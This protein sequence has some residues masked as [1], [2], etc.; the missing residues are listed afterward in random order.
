MKKKTSHTTIMTTLEN[1]LCI[2]CGL[3][4]L[5]CPV[6][7]I[8]M[9]WTDKS[10]WEP[11]IDDSKCTKCGMCLNVCPN[12]SKNLNKSAKKAL[13]FKEEYGLSDSLGNKFAITWDNR[14]DVREKSPSGGTSTSLLEN[15]LKNNLVDCVVVAR[16]V[17]GKIGE[18][19]FET[20]VC[21]DSKDLFES[22]CSA[23]GPL[24]YDLVLAEVADRNETCA[25][26]VLPCLMRGISNLPEK[27]RKC[28]KYTIGI[29]C[30]HCVNDQFGDFLAVG[31]GIK[32]SDTFS[33][34]YRNNK[35]IPDANAYNTNFNIKD[36]KEIC[37]PR[38]TNGFTKVWR[39][40]FFA[41]E[42]CL[43]CPDF[44]VADADI[45]VKDAWGRLSVEPLGITL[46]IVRNSEIDDLLKN[47]SDD[48]KIYYEECDSS[49]IK[50][51]QNP[52]AAYKQIDFVT[53]WKHNKLLKK[54]DIVL[55]EKQNVLVKKDFL[56]KRRTLRL[57]SSLAAKLG[58]STFAKCHKVL[59]LLSSVLNSV[60]KSF[61][62]TWRFLYRCF[63]AIW[64]GFIRFIGLREPR[65]TSFCRYNVKEI[66]FLNKLTPNSFRRSSAFAVPDYGSTKTIDATKN[67]NIIKECI[68]ENNACSGDGSSSKDATKDVIINKECGLEN[69]DC[70]GDGSS[71]KTITNESSN[72]KSKLKILITGGYGYGNVGDEAQL[73]ANIRR[74]QD[75][76]DCSI[77]VFSPNPEYTSKHHG[78]E[79]CWAPRV[80]LFNSNMS[81]DYGSSNK[82]FEKTFRKKKRRLL[83]SAR[84]LRAGINLQF[85]SLEEAEMLNTIKQADVLHVSGGGF[86][87]GMTRSRLWETA[88]VMRLAYL[89]GT[90]VILT[91][92]TIGVFKSQQ[93]IK[94]TKWGLEKA[95]YISLRD[96]EESEKD[97]KSI[98]ISG[99]HVQS[100]FDDALFCDKIDDEISENILKEQLPES[101]KY[102]VANFHYWGQSI[103]MQKKASKRF[104]ELC[105][106]IVEKYDLQIMFVPM[107][108]SDEE[109]EQAVIRHM[110]SQNAV[111]LKYNYDY[112]VARGVISKAE[113]LLTMKHHPII[114]AHGEGVPVVSVTLDDYYYR[115][116]LGAM[117][118]CGQE[119][120]CLQSGEFFSEDAENIIDALYSKL[121]IERSNIHKY[122]DSVRGLNDQAQRLFLKE[123]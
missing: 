17:D 26:T 45:S 65:D 74:W 29:M 89:L 8:E 2:S 63:V 34:N 96:K 40:Y 103:T 69:N 85:T 53:R 82:A 106:H 20:F 115:K 121:I 48:N 104:A 52:T 38:L 93:D 47:L 18:P 31:N 27:Y 36:K 122:L 67:E 101:K 50:D 14:D 73:G 41:R 123:S 3:C 100:T 92:Q 94:L 114:F 110:K 70:S 25:I 99:K 116:N 112:K 51:S 97:L 84:F 13:E 117:Q 76:T 24:R 43:Y 9:V 86:L 54:S 30:S 19:H 71:P 68:L 109:A 87:T 119:K 77:K 81:G 5:V 10:C 49:E 90:P 83:L 39:E 7:C 102:V 91:G 79:S 32:A 113:F 95:Q 59:S 105:D 46:A 108:L 15:M 42:A 107:A 120:Y 6:D 37:T 72:T 56:K 78:V 66:A 98:G 80:V 11:K 22:R 1:N 4:K 16:P 28:I 33:I 88:L 55:K 44:Y 62:L 58:C 57:T 75:L 64:G 12:S 35:N 23:Y 60:T 21:R 61:Q 111:I 118:N